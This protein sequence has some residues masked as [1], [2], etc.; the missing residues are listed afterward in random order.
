MLIHPFDL[1]SERD[2]EILFVADHHVDQGG[3][4]SIDLPRA[5]APADSLPQRFAVVEVIRDDRSMPLRD[6]HGLARDERRSFRQSAENAAAMKPPRAFLAK[7]LFPVNGARLE[8]RH[9]S[10]AA[11]GTT[12]GGARAEAAFGEVQPVARSPSHTVVLNPLDVRLINA[13]FPSGTSGDERQSF[14]YVWLD[15]FFAYLNETKKKH[16]KLILC[17]DYNIA[18]RILTA[19]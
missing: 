2:G 3:E 17:G 7:D 15:E 5:G 10:V 19:L 4:T 16:P 9:R 12:D 18:R 6:L 8:L 11:I 14:K 1:E 13:Y